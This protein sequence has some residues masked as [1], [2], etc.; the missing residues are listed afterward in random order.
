MTDSMRQDSSPRAP[1][2]RVQPVPPV[3]VTT[4]DTGLTPGLISDLIM[5]ALY[6]LGSRTGDQLR[7]FIRLP[8]AVLDEQ[9]VVSAAAPPDRGS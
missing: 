9:L 7:S 4:E 8:F 1:E 2:R 5:K 6:T 3:P